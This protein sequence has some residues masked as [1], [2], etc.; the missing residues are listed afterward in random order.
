MIRVSG[1]SSR[2]GGV[3]DG[4]NTIAEARKE[5][6]SLLSY[7]PDADIAIVKSAPY[8]RVHNPHEERLLIVENVQSEISSSQLPKA[9]MLRNSEGFRFFRT[10]RGIEAVYEGNPWAIWQNNRWRSRD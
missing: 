3:Y 10:S 1:P 7:A 9:A 6:Q 8:H 4:G 5:A 2:G